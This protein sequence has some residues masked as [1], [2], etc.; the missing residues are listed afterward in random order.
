MLFSLSRARR[1]GSAVLEA[2]AAQTSPVAAILE[3]EGGEHLFS[4]KVCLRLRVHYR[5]LQLLSKCVT[6]MTCFGLILLFSQIIDVS[7]K[8]EGG[9][10]KG[11]V[12][13]DGLEGHEHHQFV[14]LFQNE[15]LI[16]QEIT[17]AD[18]VSST[19][20][21]YVVHLISLS[22]KCLHLTL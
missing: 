3:Q 15:F 4:A 16:A 14:I 22:S 17:S 13:L 8:T 10:A 20:V 1:L 2:R 6:I 19:A 18:K 21:S 5:L 7:R 9:F 11:Q 12:T